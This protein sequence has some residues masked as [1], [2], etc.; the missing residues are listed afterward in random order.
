MKRAKGWMST[1]FSGHEEDHLSLT[2]QHLRIIAR[3][4]HSDG[5]AT[6]VQVL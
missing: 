3:L 2:Y 1:R 6:Q 5:R 4:W